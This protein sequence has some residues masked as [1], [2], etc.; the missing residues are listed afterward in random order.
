MMLPGEDETVWIV[1]ADEYPVPAAEVH[2]PAVEFRIGRR[3]RGHIGVVRPH[4]LHPAQVHRLQRL[5]IR[6]PA[7]GFHQ[8][9]AHDFRFAQAGGGIVG[10][11]SRIRHQHLVARVQ[12]GQRDDQDSLFGARQRLDFGRWIQRHPIPARIPV[13]EGFPQFGDAHIGLIGV[14][15]VAHGGGAQGIDGRL[16]RTPVRG[17][18]AKIDHGLGAAVRVHPGDLLVLHRK[19]V[20]LDATGAI[21]WLN[22]HRAD[23]YSPS[24]WNSSISGRTAAIA[25]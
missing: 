16:R 5:E 15:S 11:I 8:V 4:H 20:F 1:V 9:V 19:V 12:E 2:Q 23:L 25:C 14:H 6:L 18:Y 13:R 17:P 22:D 3:S 7:K 24:T 21:C 10:R